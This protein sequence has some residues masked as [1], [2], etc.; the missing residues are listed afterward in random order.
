MTGRVNFWN[1]HTCI[2]QSAY[3]VLVQLKVSSHRL[4]SFFSLEMAVPINHCVTLFK[5][6]PE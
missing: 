3:T 6:Q 1:A 2:E 4:S 5:T